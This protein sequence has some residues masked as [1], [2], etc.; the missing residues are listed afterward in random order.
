MSLPSDTYKYLG[1]FAAMLRC[2]VSVAPCVRC[3]LP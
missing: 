1:Y 3:Y 2:L